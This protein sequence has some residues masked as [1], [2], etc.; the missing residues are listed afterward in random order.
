[1]SI[2]APVLN[3]LI[4]A[5]RADYERACGYVIAVRDTPTNPAD[6]YA[7]DTRDRV[8]THAQEIADVYEWRLEQLEALA[9]ACIADAR[10]ER[11][12]RYE[13]WVSVG[14]VAESIANG[15]TQ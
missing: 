13:N 2:P 5:A 4:L 14:D 7:A 15:G 12:T 11:R 3:D 9:F 10:E 8:W 6:P 1:M